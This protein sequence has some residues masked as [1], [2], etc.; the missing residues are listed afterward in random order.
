MKK[1]SIALVCILGLALLLSGSLIAKQYSDEEVAEMIAN[2]PGTQQYPQA[3][4]LILLKQKSVHYNDDFSV[5]SDEHLVVKL[6]QD[7]AR[8]SFADLKRRYDQDNDSIVILRQSPIWLTARY[9][10]LNPRRSMISP[11]P[12]WQMLRC[13]QIFDT[14]WSP[15]PVS[16]PEFRLS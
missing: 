8:R 3:S 7:R 12:T 2:A 9:W 6:L 10:K 4:A 11:Q 16:L 13:I 15:S 14:R 5:V 1:Y